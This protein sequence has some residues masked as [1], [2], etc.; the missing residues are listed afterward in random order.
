MILNED[1]FALI[2]KYFLNKDVDFFNIRTVNKFFKRLSDKMW[3]LDFDYI[4]PPRTFVNFSKCQVCNKKSERNKSLPYGWFPRPIYIYCKNF[5]CTRTIIRNIVSN[6]TKN[7][8][9]LLTSPIMD[10]DN[11]MCP[12]SDGTLSKCIF[13]RKW[14]WLGDNKNPRIRCMFESN[15][16]TGIKD[17]EL[18]LIDK[19]LL[20]KY[21]IVRL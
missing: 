2:Y 14:L 15:G 13:E 8:I 17:I 5:E 12:R 20:G 21:K 18:Q 19:A 1:L 10:E 6:A 3:F 9:A 16:S 7:N 4:F 11:G